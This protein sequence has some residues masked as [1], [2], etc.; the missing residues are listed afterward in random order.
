MIRRISRNIPKRGITRAARPI[1]KKH[2]S[3]KPIEVPVKKID[4]FNNRNILKRSTKYRIGIL[5]VATGK[6]DK[7]TD[8]LYDS[9]RKYFLVDHDVKFVLFTDSDKKFGD[10]VKTFKIE[11]KGFPG[12]TL[13]R[14]HYFLTQEEY[15]LYNFD[16]VYYLDIDMLIVDHVGDEIIPIDNNLIGTCHP[17]FTWNKNHG[18]FETNPIS[19]AFIQKSAELIY[20][21]GGFNGGVASP[22]MKMSRNISQNIDRDLSKDYIAIWHD[23][24][25]LN[26]YF[27][28][29]SPLTLDPGYCYPENWNIPFKKKIIALDKNH[30]EIRSNQ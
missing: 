22:F 24:S 6:Y 8:P 26:K 16:L 9:I 4:F 25:H 18:S 17:G 23:E 30:E 10:D 20:Y 2:P 5:N 12:D 7:F 11:R 28:M 3:L 27:S 21:A 19:T 15:I 29:Y 13:F 14:Y 1:P